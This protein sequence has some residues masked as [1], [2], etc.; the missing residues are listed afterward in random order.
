MHQSTINTWSTGSQKVVNIFG[1][2]PHRREKNPLRMWPG[3]Y[4]SALG[5]FS[6]SSF[7]DNKRIKFEFVC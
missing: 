3:T 2:Y 7:E 1:R 5:F 6:R 4:R